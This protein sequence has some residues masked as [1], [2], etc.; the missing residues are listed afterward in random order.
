MFDLWYNLVDFLTAFP[1]QPEFQAAVGVFKVVFILMT[2]GMIGL[3]IWLRYKAGYFADLKL[4]YSYYFD[5][6]K[7]PEPAAALPLKELR[8][9]WS[10]LQLRLNYQDEAQWKLA[11]IEADNFFDHVLNLLNYQGESMGERLQKV[12]PEVLPAINEVWRV[13]KLRNALV[14]DATFRLSFNQARDV[15]ETYGK[16]LRDLK[17]FE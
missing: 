8:E 11:V 13:H 4:E 10:Q 9:Y 1:K 7:K 17:I 6:K 16:A 2:L 14:H 12:R 15:I 3:A 5:G